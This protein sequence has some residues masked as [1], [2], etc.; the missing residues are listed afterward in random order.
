MFLDVARYGD[1]MEPD[2]LRCF[3]PK[4]ILALDSGSVALDLLERGWIC[5]GASHLSGSGPGTNKGERDQE[6]HIISFKSLM[7]LPNKMQMEMSEE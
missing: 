6:R 4:R 3:A 5:L 1:Q 7:L 2:L